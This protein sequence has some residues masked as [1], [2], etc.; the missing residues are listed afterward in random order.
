MRR[1]LLG[2]A[3][4]IGLGAFAQSERI[5]AFHT[6]LTVAADGGLTVTEEINIHAE[7]LEFKRGIVRRLPLGFTDH[8]GK[9]HRVKYDFT[10][11]RMGGKDSPY[12]TDEEGDNY[13][14]YVGDKDVFLQPGDYQYRITYTTTGQVGFFPE[15]DEI[16]WNVNG[17]GWNFGVDS[18]SALIHLPAAARVLQ[19][20]CYTGI[21]GST[22]H[23]CS[24]TII[25]AHTVRFVGRALGAYEGLTVAVGF[26]K[27]VVAEPPPPTLFERFGLAIVGGIITLLLLVYYFIT[28]FRFGRDP[29]SPT[30]IP[31][32]E[33]PDNLSPAS[34][35]MVMNGDYKNDL[36]T[37]AMISLAVKGRIRIE[38]E[39][40]KILGILTWKKYVIH[41][42]GD[43]KDL[44][45]EEQDLFSDMF[46]RSK[47]RFVI[48]GRYDVEV[49]S[50]ADGFRQN[51]REQWKAFLDKGKNRKLR[52]LPS[53]TVILGTI[54]LFVLH[55][56]LW[57]DHD[58]FFLL[59]FLGLNLLLFLVYRYLVKRPSE[60]KLALRAR[61]QGF[62]MY[63]GA[64]EEKQLQHFNPPTMTPEVFE[65]YLPYAIALGVEK[66]W[67]ERF[68]DLIDKALVDSSYQPGWYSGSIG[69]FGSFSHSMNSSF[70]S[71]VQG[72][73]TPPSSSGGSGGGGSSGGGGGGG[74]GGG[75]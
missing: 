10:E 68:Q 55:F 20:S 33:P 69:N 48:S 27:G 50:M 59:S 42:I 12:H 14:L 8:T 63:L 25:D 56:K 46:G 53:L 16:Y 54:G 65:K 43:G 49:K 47:D 5:I 41:K 31:L 51:M 19:T 45:R 13:V 9:E 39:K 58:Q 35:G 40:E 38:E 61:L 71:S 72:S 7:G 29:E 74:G 18:I 37:P 28:W 64:A 26:Q 36:I 17:N 1:A 32:F 3:L 21:A 24:D 22:E 34:V 70:S 30:A 66:V 2:A 67:G 52:I 4:A 6:D 11:V 23:A 60:E 44:P 75:W 62:K 73:S 57:G 15:F